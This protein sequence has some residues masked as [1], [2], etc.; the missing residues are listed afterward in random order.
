MTV[1]QYHSSAIPLC[2]YTAKMAA[3]I[4]LEDEDRWPW[5]ERVADAVSL[6]NSKGFSAVLACS[7]LKRSYRSRIRERLNKESLCYFVS[8]QAF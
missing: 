3:G 8:M 1:I 2:L 6:C 4:A 7:A 5:L